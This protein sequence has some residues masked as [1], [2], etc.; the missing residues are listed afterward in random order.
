M[1]A[2]VH[3]HGVWGPKRLQQ[4]NGQLVGERASR[5]HDAEQM[6]PKMTMGMHGL[7]GH[8]SEGYRTSFLLTLR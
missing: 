8:F 2:R 7:V 6:P 4:C 3:L 5:T 1:P